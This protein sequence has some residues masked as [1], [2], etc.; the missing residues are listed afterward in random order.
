MVI[1]A[2]S[3]SKKRGFSTSYAA[4]G[5]AKPFGFFSVCFFK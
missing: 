3:P 2:G 5:G 4:F 1:F